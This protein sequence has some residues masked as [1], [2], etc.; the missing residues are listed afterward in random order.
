MTIRELSGYLFQLEATS[1]RLQITR[2]LS[3]LFTKTQVSEIDLVT[4]LILGSLAPRYEGMVF[5]IAERMMLEVLAK[6]YSVPVTEVK[7]QYKQKG[8][9]GAVAQVLALQSDCDT[10]IPD[11]FFKLKNVAE[12][13]GEGSQERKI[14][15]MAKILAGLDPLSARYVARIPVGK[16]R[17]GFSDKTIIDA[18]SWMEYGDKSGRKP[19]ES[20]LQVLPDVGYLAKQV[21]SVGIKI[22]SQNVIPKVGIPVQAML[23]QRLKSPREMIDKMKKV[24]VEPK[25]DGLRILIHF[26]RGKGGFVKAYTR[27]LKE[28]SW[29][30]PEL[31][32]A[33]NYLDAEEAILDS[34]AV[35]V[36]EELKAM[37]NFQMTM[38]RRRKHDIAQTAAKVAID[39]YVFD[40]LAKNGNNL[41]GCRYQERRDILDKTIKSGGLFQLT[42]YT[43]TDDP[44]E[45]IKLHKY[46]RDQGL[47]GV[48]VKRYDSAYV[49]GRTGWRWVKMKEEEFSTGKLADTIDCVI[50]GYTA[51]RGKRADFGIGQFLA[52]VKDG[53][54]FVT[55]TKVGTG[56]SDELFVSLGKELKKIVTLQ[57]PKEYAV[58]NILEPDYWVLPQVVVEIAGD[59]LTRSTN[60]TSGLGLRFPRLV[61]I[62]SDK[63]LKDVTTLTE[64]ENLYTL[65]NK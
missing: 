14:A 40:I 35:G 56:L 50:M 43:V 39:F 59:D 64:V 5:N 16:L 18:L 48:M 8:D 55:L 36:S 13:E 6:A 63:G 11:L 27:N 24:S 38:T 29:M 20:A 12:D 3:Q 53:D 54:N 61:K 51:G 33:E 52:G 37:V 25:L 17:L 26:K 28:V 41:M 31:N 30:F 2:I 19:L 47:E 32:K 44:A 10:Q 65:Q 21:K 34:E 23:A 22:A 46:Y 42:K 9:L 60:H 45:I 4:Y 58:L 1:S 7:Q 57:K 62:R 49:P 15:D